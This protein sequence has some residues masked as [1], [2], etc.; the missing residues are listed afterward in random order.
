MSYRATILSPLPSY[1]LGTMPGGRDVTTYSQS[2]R[3]SGSAS[4]KPATS[5]YSASSLNRPTSRPLPAGPGPLDT[6]GKRLSNYSSSDIRKNSN[7]G[8]YKTPVKATQ[9]YSNFEYT[10]SIGTHPRRFSPSTLSSTTKD[11]GGSRG[12]RSRSVSNAD[13]LADTFSSNLKLNGGVDSVKASPRTIDSDDSLYGTRESR[14][15]K[16]EQNLNDSNLRAGTRISRVSSNAIG[17]NDNTY[18]PRNRDS[19]GRGSV[20]KDIFDDKRKD[21]TSDFGTSKSLS[22]Q[23]SSNS[24]ST[25]RLTNSKMK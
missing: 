15:D 19:T 3:R 4:R 10:P 2:Y 22:R 9:S 17:S 25:V 24:L 21:S 8:S 16:H 23:S 7:T 13:K 11:L 18:T 14:K 12:I 5:L 6:S 20:Q 1:G